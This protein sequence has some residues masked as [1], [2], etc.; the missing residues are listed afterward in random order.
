MFSGDDVMSAASAELIIVMA[1]TN[2]TLSKVRVHNFH[3]RRQLPTPPYIQPE[4]LSM[5]YLNGPERLDN[6]RCHAGSLYAAVCRFGTGVVLNDPSGVA[7]KFCDEQD[8]T[9]LG[10]NFRR[11]WDLSYYLSERGCIAKIFAVIEPDRLVKS[12]E[13]VRP[14]D[15]MNKAWISNL[16][17][18]LELSFTSGKDVFEAR[19]TKFLAQMDQLGILGNLV[20]FES[21]ADRFI[22]HDYCLG[23]EDNSFT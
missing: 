5:F 23:D 22:R 3:L 20:T 4:S 11:N 15:D 6:L 8:V 2:V 18:I 13:W 19:R 12:S 17:Q 21:C 9:F 10:N 14:H 16:N 1:V 7:L